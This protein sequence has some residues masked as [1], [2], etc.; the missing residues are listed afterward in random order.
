MIRDAHAFSQSMYV[1]DFG[2]HRTAR[3][4]RGGPPRS[5]PKLA[6]GSSSSEHWWLYIFGMEDGLWRKG[7]GQWHPWE[8]VMASGILGEG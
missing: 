6:S 5:W 4:A 2:R 3:T 8:R 1:I 7:D